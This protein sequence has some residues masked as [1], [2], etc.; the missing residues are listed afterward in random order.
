MRSRTCLGDRQ[1][2]EERGAVAAV[3]D[4]PDAAVHPRDQLAGDVEAQPGSSDSA[5]EVGVEPEEL[6]E[7]TVLLGGRDAQPLV[8]EAESDAPAAAADLQLDSPAVR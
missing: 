4:D 3:G 1:F 6:L 5:R 8:A 7:D 2:Q